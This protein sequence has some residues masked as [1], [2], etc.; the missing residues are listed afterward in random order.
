[1]SSNLPSRNPTAYLG[2]TPTYPGQIYFRRVAPNNARDVHNY[3]PGDTWIDTSSNQIWMLSKLINQP[4]PLTK[5]ANWVNIS[6]A[7]AAGIAT[8]TA[9]IG[10]PVAPALGNVD[11]AGTAAQGII[12]DGT[13]AANTITITAAD[14]TTVTKGVSRFNPAYFTVVAG[15]VSLA[16]NASFYW[17]ETVGPQIL[18]PNR[19][20]IAANAGG[21]TFTLPAVSAQGDVVAIQ[22][23]GVGGWVITQGAGQ[24][25]IFNS[26]TFSTPG[27]GGNVSSTDAYDS[28]YLLCYTANLIWIAIN[29]KGNLA[30]V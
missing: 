23:Q 27:A 19:G 21:T 2:V 13:L 20:W 6:G 4:P 24:Q 10:G 16:G 5:V 15:N 29:Y 14:A 3:N 1:M 22:G 8:L 9:D 17:A 11:I 18:T 28:I 26:I 7:G 12:T 30:F 25:I